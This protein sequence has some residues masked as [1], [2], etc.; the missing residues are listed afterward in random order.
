MKEQ[1]S[2]ESSDT[3]LRRYDTVHATLE[4]HS[5]FQIDHRV[6]EVLEGLG[7]EADDFY[8]SLIHI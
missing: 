8:L 3:L 6:A 1:I 7:F 2:Q 4:Q 5:G